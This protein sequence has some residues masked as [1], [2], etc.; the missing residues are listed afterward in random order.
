MRFNRIIKCVK[1]S[2][3]SEVLKIQNRH[4]SFFMNRSGH[5][6]LKEQDPETLQVITNS[7]ILNDDEIEQYN[8]F[9]EEIILKYE[10]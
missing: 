7:F 2:I 6:V 3:L 9:M 5:F 1:I 8:I 4:F 10:F